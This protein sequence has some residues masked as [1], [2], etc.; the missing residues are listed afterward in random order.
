MALSRERVNEDVP[1]VRFERTSITGVLGTSGIEDAFTFK[2]TIN[3][4]LFAG[5]VRKELVP[6]LKKVIILFMIILLFIK[7]KM[8]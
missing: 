8:Q 4:V 1:D 3:S 2:G 7:K 6:I 5:Y